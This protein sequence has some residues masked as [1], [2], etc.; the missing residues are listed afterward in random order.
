LVTATLG[1]VCGVGAW[2]IAGIATVVLL[3]LSVGGGSIER[4]LHQRWLRKS[5]E[6]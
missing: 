6:E 4:G 1:I 2:Q 5:P 3:L